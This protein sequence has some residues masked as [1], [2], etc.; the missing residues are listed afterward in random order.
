MLLAMY[1]TQCHPLTRCPQLEYLNGWCPTC[2]AWVLMLQLRSKCNAFRHC[3]VGITSWLL[4]L[5]VVARR[6][7]SWVHSLPSCTN[8]VRHLRVF[9]LWIR[10][11]SLPTRRC[12]NSLNSQQ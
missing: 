6:L 11:G 2:D 7:L 9:L 1:P 4:H 8:Q 10:R 12:V 5:Q 3:S